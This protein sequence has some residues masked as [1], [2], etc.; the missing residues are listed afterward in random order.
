MDVVRFHILCSIGLLADSDASVFNYDCIEWSSY[1]FRRVRR[2]AGD[3]A[4]NPMI[5]P[6]FVATG[7]LFSRSS[8]RDSGQRIEP[9]IAF[10]D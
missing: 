4:M 2:G 6:G 1:S 10:R 7:F 3:S 9:H 5:E 8:S